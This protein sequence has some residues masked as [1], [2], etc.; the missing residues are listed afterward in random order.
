MALNGHTNRLHVSEQSYGPVN[1]ISGNRWL[2]E[3]RENV[4]IILR[5][6]ADKVHVSM[7]PVAF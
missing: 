2:I 6:T 7:G 1:T 5:S 4:G 3:T